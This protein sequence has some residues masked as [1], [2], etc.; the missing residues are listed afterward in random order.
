MKWEKIGKIFDP[1][2]HVLP[3]NCLAFA[4]APQVLLFDDF[5][6][7]YFSTRSLDASNGKYLSH[8]AYVDMAL[9]FKDIL[10]VSG[11]TVIPLG[12]PGCFDE[13]GIF[14][15][16]VVRH[17]NKIYGY[18]GGVNRRSSVPVDSA[19]GIAVSNDEG[20]T[21]KRLGDGP[22]LSASLHEPCLIADP[23]VQ[24]HGNQFHMWYIFGK[25][26]QHSGTHVEQDRVYKIGH[27]ISDDGVHWKKRDGHEII[28]SKL[29]ADECQA[30]PTVISMA[31]RHHMF[32]C[33]REASD[34]RNNRER[35]YRIGHAFS[36]DL[37]NW[38][39]QDEEMRLGL[40]DTGWDSDMTCYPHVFACKNEIYMLYNG[41]EFGRYG[42]G[43]A[44]LSR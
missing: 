34:F 43:L 36:D 19:I 1:T 2:E 28:A 38:Q 42:F 39:R 4:Q 15:L 44:K 21:F 37:I 33:Y 13:H 40:S 11:H 9:N 14:P 8:I 41:N 20:K 26:W 35:S 29:G 32:F 27:A 22:V 7:I 5:I 16:N 30:L 17:A 18:I 23:F 3:G 31:G 6:R 25:G 10:A 24:V 12:K